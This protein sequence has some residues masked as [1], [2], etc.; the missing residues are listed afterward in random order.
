MSAPEDI[1]RAAISVVVPMVTESIPPAYSGI[2]LTAIRV[3]VE[4]AIQAC[5]ISRM[6]VTAEPA[7]PSVVVSIRD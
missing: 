2:A 3:A 7:S 4:A 5:Q 1:A 6:E